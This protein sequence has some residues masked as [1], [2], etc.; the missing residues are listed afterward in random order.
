MAY[1]MRRCTGLSPSRTSGSKMTQLDS[2]RSATAPQSNRP[3]GGQGV[4]P[5]HAPPQGMLDVIRR[6]S[7]SLLARQRAGALPSPELF[8][9]RVDA[10]PAEQLVERLNAV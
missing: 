9:A 3:A 6:V 10:P 1:R 7:G 8:L 4:D 5:L 2:E